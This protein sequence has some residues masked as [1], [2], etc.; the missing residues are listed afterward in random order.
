[1]LERRVVTLRGLIRQIDSGDLSCISDDRARDD[2]VRS[3]EDAV[4]QLS[5]VE[6][7]L[8]GRFED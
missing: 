1:M 4:Q 8:A 3:R 2:L 6:S 5:T 7:I